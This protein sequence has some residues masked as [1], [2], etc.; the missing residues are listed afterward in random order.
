MKLPKPYIAVLFNWNKEKHSTD[1]IYFH[2]KGRKDKTAIFHTRLQFLYEKEYLRVYKY[3]RIGRSSTFYIRPRIAT[4]NL[5]DA[6]YILI[7]DTDL[8]WDNRGFLEYCSTFKISK[9]KIAP[10]C[11][12]CLFRRNKW[13]PLQEDS[14]KYKGNRICEYCIKNE[15]NQEL[16]RSNLVVSGGITRFFQQQAEREGKLDVVLENISFGTEQDPIKNPESTLFD[17]ITAKKIGNTIE[18]DKIPKLP[19]KLKKLLVSEGI[20][21]LLPIQQKAIDS[22]LLSGEDLLIVAGTTSGKTLIG[23]FAGISQ[24][25]KGK[26]FVYLSPLVALTNQKYEQFRKRYRK[27]NLTTTI[28][29][30]MSRIKVKGEFSPIIDGDFKDTNIIVATYEAFDFLLRDGKSRYMGDI[31]VIVIDEVQMLVAKE[32]GFRLNGLITRMKALFPN[33]QFIYLS[34]TIGNPEKLADDLSADYVEYLDRPIP[35]ERHT[36]LTENEIERFKHL[37]KICQNEEKLVSSTGYKGQTLV[38]TN[39]RKN[40]EN[41]AKKLSRRGIHATYYHAGLTF[42]YRKK[43]E[44]GFEKGKYSTVVTTIALGAGVDFPASAVIFENLAM[45]IEW[46]S[47]AEFHQMLGRAGRLGFHDRGKVFLLIEPG[48]KIFVGQKETEEQIAFELLTKPIEDV[49]PVLE[50]IQEEEELL[51]T[52]TAFGKVNITKDKMI[53]SNILGRT[54]LLK[55]NMRALRKMEMIYVENKDIFPTKIGKAVSLSFLSPSY[56]LRL[57]QEIK[58]Y[59]IKDFSEDFALTLAIKIQPFR[60]A[61]LTS[62]LHGEIERV[63]KSTISTNLFSGVVLDLY[64]GNGWGRRNPTKLII[65]SFADWT[66]NIFICDCADK[67]FCGCGEINFTKIIVEL[68]NKGFSPIKITEEIRKRHNI[69]LYPGDLFSYLDS[70]VHNLEAVHRL[71][72]VLDKQKLQSLARVAVKNIENPKE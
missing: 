47:V 56:A 45:G 22:G 38:F 4:E 27:I 63:L 68:R 21:N 12:N 54:G 48:R 25:L 6:E 64:S 10:I 20:K 32:R 19:V 7:P 60:S 70:L 23:E 57:V 59:K 46:L 40:C 62:K 30:G 14:V 42:M 58:R 44:R 26:K 37:F 24:A 66:K 55:D 39:S 52:V 61:H 5:R 17:I 9:P 33:A 53:F 49:D 50:T 15:L 41:L 3:L 67:P 31:G 69:Q 2:L 11:W 28:R 51:A 16:Q 35:L 71:A 34:A 1:I 65:D 13:T 29:V 43:V 18:V 72:K 8:P 36:I